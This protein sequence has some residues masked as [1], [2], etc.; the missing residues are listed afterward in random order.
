VCDNL[1]FSG[2]V[3]LARRHTVYIQRDLPE[4]VSRAVGQLGDLRRQ[5]EERLA[6]YKTTQ[7]ER[8]DAH[9][10]LIEALRMNVLPATRL[11]VAVKE[12]IKGWKFDALPRRTQA[13]HG[14]LDGACGLAA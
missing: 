13:L 1:C 8:R 3:V 9:H 14:L 7:L 6:A 12:A 2:E 11:P 4:L 5:Q 10:L